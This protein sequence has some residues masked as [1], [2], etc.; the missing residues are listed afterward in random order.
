MRRKLMSEYPV[1]LKYDA[2]HQWVRLDN[3]GLVTT[4]VT[5]E[6]V[7]RLTTRARE[8]PIVSVQLPAVGSALV[9]TSSGDGDGYIEGSSAIS[10]LSCPIAGTVTEVNSEVIDNPDL[11]R[12]DCYGDG[13]LYRFKPNNPADLNGLMGVEAYAQYNEMG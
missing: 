4:G 9:G 5:N 13:W 6:K 3:D 7:R 1:F 2:N 12:V 8:T 10:E 11:V